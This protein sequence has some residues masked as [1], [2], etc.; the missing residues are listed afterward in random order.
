VFAP[1]TLKI[2]AGI[3]ILY[4]ALVAEVYLGPPLF[5]QE[6][7][8]YFVLATFLAAHLFHA[9]GVPGLLEH[10]GYCGW[11]PCG[12]TPLGWAFLAVFWL[13]VFWLIAWAAAR[14]SAAWAAK[15]PPAAP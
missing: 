6:A 2:F 7:A 14:L 3:L 8:A 9:L 10:G 12:P 4:A 11:G 5:F 15:P 1:R 13:L